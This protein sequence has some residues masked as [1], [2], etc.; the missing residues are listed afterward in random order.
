MVLTR[1]YRICM[2]LTTKEYRIGQLY[3]IARHS[4]EQ[5][6]SEEGVEVVEKVECV[7]PEHGTGQYTEKRIHLFSKLPYWIQSIIPR[8]GFITEKAWNYY[9]FTITGI[10]N[11]N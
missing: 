4:H 1:E 8:L 10:L 9:P 11:Y 6:E 2:P 7:H 3:M 5:S